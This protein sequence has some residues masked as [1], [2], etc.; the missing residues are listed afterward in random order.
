[1][2]IIRIIYSTI[3]PCIFVL[4]SF[5]AFAQ[6][7]CEVQLIGQVFERGSHIPVAFASVYIIDLKRGVQ[8]DEKGQFT[9]ELP[10][11]NKLMVQISQFDY[12][13]DTFSIKTE[14]Q[15]DKQ[16]FYLTPK[17][18]ELSTITV[19]AH[20]SE[21]VLQSNVT[22]ILS[23]RDL[24]EQAGKTLSE[25]LTKVAG[26]YNIKTGPGIN[27]PMIHGLYG[28][29]IQLVNNEVSQMGQQWGADHAP[30]IDPFLASN[31]TVLKGAGSVKY[32]QRAIGGVI[33]VSPEALTYDT[34]MHGGLNLVGISNGRGGAASFQ[35]TGSIGLKNKNNSLNWRVQ[36]SVKKLGDQHTPNYNLTN[37][38]LQEF[39]FSLAS[40]Y[41]NDNYQIDAF[42]SSFQTG[43]GI[44]R[45]SHVGNEDDLFAAIN[46]R[47]PFYTEEFTY[48]IQNPRQTVKHQLLKTKVHF[49]WERLGGMNLIY[50]YQ[51]NNRQ[52]YDVRRSSSDNRPNIDLQLSSHLFKT[53]L[54]HEPLFQ[55]LEGEIGID[56]E[57][58]NNKTLPGT[59]SVP[60]IPNYESIQTGLFISEHVKLKDLI[61][62][63]GARY[64][65]QNLSVL[66]F[67]EQNAL[68]N[69]TYDFNLFSLILGANYNLSSQLKVRANLSRSERSPNVNE[70]FSQGLHHSL[71]SIEI[72]DPGLKKEL[73]NKILFSGEYRRSERLQFT[74]NFHTSFYNGYIYLE[75][76]GSRQT[77]RG[78]FPVYK[79]QQTDALLYGV[80]I[81]LSY[82]FFHH[83]VNN[84]Q[85][86]MVR[87]R[88]LANEI[89][90]I[91]MP[92][93]RI[94]NITNWR[95]N[96][97]GFLKELDLKAT[98]NKVFKQYN[99]PATERFPFPNRGEIQVP[100]G[101]LTFDFA[102]AGTKKLNNSQL[103]LSF[104]VYNLLDKSYTDY[105]N[106]L[107]YY[108]EESGRNFELKLNYIF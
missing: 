38:A 48:T 23:T 63:F 47:P 14:K 92:S 68:I 12:V 67:D 10:C 1:M 4:G 45:G 61:V 46:Q 37:T 85:F 83:F 11:N 103:S 5:S 15:H 26:V 102:I 32:G 41:I 3:I 86:S 88:D 7:N 50:A 91:F 42:Y 101:Y 8:S 17:E 96:N 99:A 105:L 27:K 64:D 21:R 72:G 107:R 77:I 65:Y 25:T 95:L 44:L 40:N 28:S 75:P 39:N 84:T 31:I 16:E 9:L 53:N 90:L 2:S 66:K 57:Y 18:V 34:T 43:I 19:H 97:I 22:T 69:P 93:D 100:D 24:R 20:Q 82:E 49:D 76:S 94:R 35:L 79:Y 80:D 74:T 52:E 13:M 106:R 62:E 55:K 87:G 51:Q 36:S 108:A 98:V 71:A 30:E 29:R 70:L 78:A 33:L 6:Q 60:L 59:G 58:Q 81:G 104:S 89:M 73:N 56:F 54:A